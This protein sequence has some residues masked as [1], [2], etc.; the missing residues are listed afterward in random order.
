MKSRIGILFLKEFMP[1]LEEH[2]ELVDFLA[3]PPEE[4]IGLTATGDIGLL[5]ELGSK[6]SLHLHS[7][8]L[9][10][11]SVEGL[12]EQWLQELAHLCHLVEV[13]SVSDHLGFSWSGK[14]WT[15]TPL[16]NCEFT[17]Q[18]V[19]LVAAAAKR[20]KE[21]LGLP[22]SLE[23]NSFCIDWPTSTI[24][25]PVFWSKATLAGEFNLLLDIPN[26]IGRCNVTQENPIQVLKSFPLTAVSQ[27]HIAGGDWLDEYHQ[28]TIA[29]A[30]SKAITEEVW[31]LLD[32][33]FDLVGPRDIVLERTRSFDAD[34]VLNELSRLRKLI[35]RYEQVNIND[36]TTINTLS[37]MKEDYKQAVVD[38]TYCLLKTVNSTKTSNVESSQDEQT[39][40]EHKARQELLLRLCVDTGFRSAFSNKS[41]RSHILQSVGIQED[42]HSYS[43]LNEEIEFQSR[44]IRLYNENEFK[45]AYP[46]VFQHWVNAQ[47]AL[48][49]RFQDNPFRGEDRITDLLIFANYLLS[50]VATDPLLNREKRT[51]ITDLI[52]YRV[53]SH[54]S[55]QR[56][57]QSAAKVS[58]CFYSSSSVKTMD[59]FWVNPT[60]VI[61]RFNLDVTTAETFTPQL[62]PDGENE[63]YSFYFPH[64][65]HFQVEVCQVTEQEAN[66]LTN[67]YVLEG[68]LEKEVISDLQSFGLLIS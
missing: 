65:D 7:T 32:Y 29:R 52:R 1:F 14:Y 23:N 3:V 44:L 25:E 18:T 16:L 40:K 27:I 43:W 11:A 48:E 67:S 20:V 64:L 59:L 45:N 36:K 2:S 15:G 55:L 63:Y 19:Y 57:R 4:Y 12:N 26:L 60:L 46:E 66:L 37:S 58:N 10:I 53:A 13:E 47:Q 38:P 35:D 33:C 62:L 6:Y 51:L 8:S 49:S 34:E 9:S 30:H 68:T 5:K 54:R 17:D 31:E 56:K 24:T 22:F 42:K 28:G 39:K 41:V 21:Y 61:E 50:G